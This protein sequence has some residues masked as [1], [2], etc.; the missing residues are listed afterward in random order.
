MEIDSTKFKVK[1]VIKGD[2]LMIGDRA[3]KVLPVA[4]LTNLKL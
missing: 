4:Y 1:F 2:C 3:L